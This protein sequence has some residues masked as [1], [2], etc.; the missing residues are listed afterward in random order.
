MEQEIIERLDAIAGMQVHLL[1]H[2]HALL[3][4]V[5]IQQTVPSEEHQ[6]GFGTQGRSSLKGKHKKNRTKA[7]RTFGRKR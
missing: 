6:L 7:G 1:R 3:Q 2:F 5:A 4:G